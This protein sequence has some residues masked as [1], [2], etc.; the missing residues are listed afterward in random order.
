VKRKNLKDFGD[1]RMELMDSGP[2]RL[3]R[4]TRWPI[5]GNPTKHGVKETTRA[6]KETTWKKE[7]KQVL[8]SDGRGKQR[9]LQK[10]TYPP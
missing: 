2:Q 10:N 3:E 5:W 7:K 9:G 4:K 8:A 6:R 1:W